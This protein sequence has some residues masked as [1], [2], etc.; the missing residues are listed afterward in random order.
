[1]TA[2]NESFFFAGVLDR[3]TRPQV[4]PGIWTRLRTPPEFGVLAIGVP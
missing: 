3:Q 4:L 1:M 2:V